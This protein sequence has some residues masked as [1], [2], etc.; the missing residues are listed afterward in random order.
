MG[1]SIVSPIQVESVDV[2]P[3]KLAANEASNQLENRAY[4]QG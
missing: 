4:C 1:T 2:R 3:I